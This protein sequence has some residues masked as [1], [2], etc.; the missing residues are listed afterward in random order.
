MSNIKCLIALNHRYKF[1]KIPEQ[2]I[3]KLMERFPGVSFIV[4]SNHI[5]TNEEIP[6]AKV[7]FCWEVNNENLNLAKNLQW[8]QLASSG[9]D[10]RIPK[11][12]FSH[13]DIELTNMKGIGASSVAEFV[14]ASI[15][16]VNRGIWRA[17][18]D[19]SNGIWNRNY[20]LEDT[21]YT[22]SLSETTV[23]ILGFGA[24]GI[25][26]Y[27]L[28]TRLDVK[29]NICSKSTPNLIANNSKFYSMLEIEEFV[30]Q[31]DFLVLA[32][33][34]NN[35]TKGLI[36]FRILSLMPKNAFIINIA[37]EEI[38]DRSSLLEVLKIN[39]IKGVLFDVLSI[40]PPI[41]I[42]DKKF[43]LDEKIIITPHIA[44]LSSSYWDESIRIF[45]NNLESH[46]SG[47]VKVNIVNSF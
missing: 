25:K 37:R 27:T 24:I 6:S 46:L 10:K 11:D 32:L 33:P 30:T 5:H 34:L 39:N 26:L 31:L 2:Y 45:S 22:K 36:D 28:L 40:E 12:F 9:I 19:S 41:K 20:F 8:I 47:K 38:I 43:L 29:V 15:V 13:Y 35:Q 7:I 21:S 3:K 23:G 14:L 4:T 18:I 17:V 16:S 44:S 1:W 42:Q